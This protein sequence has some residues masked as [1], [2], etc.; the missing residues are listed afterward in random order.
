M[1]AIQV[2]LNTNT[3]TSLPTF[4]QC[5]NLGIFLPS[6]F[7]REINHGKL[8]ES[9]IIILTVFETLICNFRE[10]QALENCINPLK[11]KIRGSALVKISLFEVFDLL[12]KS[13]FT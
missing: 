1:V 6:N 4:T 12:R 8:R 13:N 2:L 9:N 5:V 11:P 3:T 7:L 10:I